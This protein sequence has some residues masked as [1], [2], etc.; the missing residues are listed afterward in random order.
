MN[1]R[2]LPT[3][4]RWEA[5]DRNTLWWWVG[6]LK[7]FERECVKRHQVRR[8]RHAFKGALQTLGYDEEGNSTAAGL[9]E[10]RNLVPLRGSVQLRVK[11]E[12]IDVKYTDMQRDLVRGLQQV[13]EMARKFEG[14]QQKRPSRPYQ[15]GRLSDNYTGAPIANGSI[16][17]GTRP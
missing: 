16:R 4:E 6:S 13:V 2:L 9:H 7:H 10:A 8:L 11:K 14:G 3:K 1:M 15:K 5:R 17:F 12:A